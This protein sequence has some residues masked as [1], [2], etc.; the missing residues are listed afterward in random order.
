VNRSEIEWT[1]YTWN[2][3][4]GCLHGCPYCYAR[5]IARRFPQNFPS[6]FEP[7][8]YP[9]RLEEPA[10]VKKPAKIFVV[11][12][13]DLFGAWV[14]QEWQDAVFRVVEENPRHT[15]QFLTKD[16]VTMGRAFDRYFGDRVPGNL[17]FGTS[18]TGSDDIGRFLSLPTIDG[19]VRFVSFEPLL[20]SISL[21]NASADWL[22]GDIDWVIIGA[23]TNPTK[24]PLPAWVDEI[25]Q[26]AN[27]AGIP[28]FLK[29]SIQSWWPETLREFPA[30][31]G[32]R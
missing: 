17:W 30:A 14:P 10:K 28:V 20:G 32:A 18:V 13:G 5:K 29:N 3:V 25:I 6:G 19:G 21:P 2:P 22:L 11:S 7:A 8:F 24:H 15:F 9:E 27:G 31:G 1:D 4:T 12:M 23:Q 26:A 16:P